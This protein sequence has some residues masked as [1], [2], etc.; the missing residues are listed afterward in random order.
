MPY[1]TVFEIG[2][3]TVDW[4]IAGSCLYVVAIGAGVAL[5]GRFILRLAIA[6][7]IGQLFVAIGLAMFAAA[8]TALTHEYWQL[9]SV[10]TGQHYKVVEGIVEDFQPM[11]YAGP[12]E[13]CITVTGERFCYSDFNS[14]A[15]FHQS[16]SHGGPVRQGQ[17]V[18]I[19]HADNAILRLEIRSDQLPSVADRAARADTERATYEADREKLKTQGRQPQELVWR[20]EGAGRGLL[21]ALHVVFMVLALLWNL[22]WQLY[23]EHWLERSPPYSFAAKLAHRLMPLMFFLLSCYFLVRNLMTADYALPDIGMALLI[24]LPMLGYLLIC[25]RAIRR[26]QR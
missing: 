3:D 24:G 16:T 26:Q 13:E 15:A 19:S 20:L 11:P 21:L 18:R 22:D 7:G 6:R 2:P 8:L 25:D 5:F 10:Y 9:S 23:S 1:I 4:W 17:P 14:T 12:S